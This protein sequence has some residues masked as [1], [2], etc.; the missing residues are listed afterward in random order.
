MPILSEKDRE[1][2]IRLLRE[3]KPL[4]EMYKSALFPSDDKEYIELTKVY[5]LVYPGKK[6]KEDIIAETLEAPLQEV[7]AFNAENPFPDGWRNMLIFGDNLMAL[8]SLYEDQRGPDKYGTKNKIRLIYIDP[9]FATKQD[10]MKDREKAYRDKIIGAQFIEF[11]RKRLILLREVLADDGSIYV[12]CDAKKS[13]YIK[14]ICDEVFQENSFL[15]QV[16]WKRMQSGRKAK[17]T[18]WHSVDDTLLMYEK[19]DHL[20]EPQYLGYSKK[21]MSR[22]T[23]IDENGRYFWD[24]IGSYSK[25]RLAL[26]EGQGRVKYSETGAKPRIKNYLHEGKG[27]IIDNIWIDIPPVN[28]QAEEDTNY[29]TQKPEQL[30]ERIIK[31]SSNTGDIILD[32]FAGS[33]T[34]LAVAE[35]LGQRWIGMDCGKLAIYTIQKRILNLTTQ[36]GSGKKD[37]RK[38]PER[39]EDFDNHLKTSKSLFLVT[40]KANKGELLIDDAFLEALHAVVSA[41]QKKGEFSLICPEEKFR[42]QSFD[43]DEE[44]RK[45]IKKDHIT[46]VVSFGEPKDKPEKEKPLTARAFALFNAGIYDNEAILNLDWQAYRGFVLKLFE[47][48]EERHSING[49]SVDGYIGVDS[50]YIW[51][52]PNCKTQTLDEGYVESLHRVMG[53]KAGERF[54]LIAPVVSFSFLMDEIRLGDTTY[55]FL[56]VPISVLARLIEKKS[57]GAFPQPCAEADVN[58]VIDAVG[59]D[60]ISPPVVKAQYLRLPPEKPDLLTKDRRDYVIRLKEFCSDTLASSPEDFENFETLSMVLVDFEFNGKVFDMDAVYWAED[61]VNAELKRKEITSSAKFAERLK[62]CDYLDIR[63][64]EE[65]A[66]DNMMAIFIDKYGNEKKQILNTTTPVSLIHDG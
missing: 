15:C 51:D 38:L 35:K 58:E 53:G 24:N 1:N 28:S 43:E 18:K 14:A 61:L 44:G 17:A 4:P 27:V 63:L 42:I 46:Y 56:K 41:T 57:L 40:E 37:E 60:F 55:V 62:E 29:P 52:Y 20:F 34:T 6:R 65:K 11:L 2:I 49:F 23:E 32:A 7:R 22:F 12:H 13:H 36:V 8:K 16:V 48:R 54:Y 10:F 33:G 59:F 5:Q 45:I 21:Y 3:G 19:Q 30:I 26:L 47:V 9:P 25:E 39:V 64:P 66:A 31:A 50:A